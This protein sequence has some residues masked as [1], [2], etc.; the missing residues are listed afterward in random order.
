[1]LKLCLQFDYKKVQVEYNSDRRLVPFA[2]KDYH[3]I[4]IKEDVV[5]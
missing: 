4:F 1:M 5:K 3:I 2:W